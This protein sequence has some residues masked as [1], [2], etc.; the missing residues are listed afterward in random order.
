MT[1]LYD[2]VLAGARAGKTVDELKQTVTMDK[3]KEWGQYMQYR[4]LNVEGMYKY[5]QTNR[6][7]N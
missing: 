4:P 6:R 5:V 7:G 3:Y 2:A 1:E